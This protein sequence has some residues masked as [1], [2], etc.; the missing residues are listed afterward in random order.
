MLNLI[1]T[2]MKKSQL[3]K[4]FKP[5]ENLNPSNGIK[6]SHPENISPPPPPLEKSFPTHET[7]S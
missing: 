2:P 4:N 1:Y 5:C 6:F 7:F 3:L